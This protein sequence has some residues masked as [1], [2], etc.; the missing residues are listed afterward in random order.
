MSHITLHS[1]E[2]LQSDK[3][4]RI[5]SEE[6]KTYHDA[7][8]HEF[9]EIV[10]FVSGSGVHTV[11]GR[12]EEVSAGDLF[13][14]NANVIHKIKPNKDNPLTVLNCIFEPLS[15]DNSFKDCKNFVDVAFYYT[16]HTLHDIEPKNYIKLRG[17]KHGKIEN[18]LYEMHDE[19]IEKESGYIHVLKTDLFKLLIYIFRFYRND[20]SQRQ[21]DNLYKK[22]IV[23]NT[24]TYIKDHYNEDI[25][26]ENIAKQ[27]YVSI[28]YLNKIF[29]EVTESTI[30][31]TIQNIRI[32]KACDLLESTNKSIETIFMETGYSDKKFFYQLF[33]RMK[34]MSP[35]EYRKKFK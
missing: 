32:N 15:I 23:Q 11:E 1:K 28:G 16:L 7:H 24:F 20:S 13:L 9:I 22:L 21:D 26:C 31:K 35:G 12:D 4:I 17:I 8:A 2:Y 19:Y 25:K 33:K 18:L 14:I 3:E 34:G 29:K 30:L 10:Y 6:V 5:F 27:N